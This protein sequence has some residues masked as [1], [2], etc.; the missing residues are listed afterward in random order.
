MSWSKISTKKVQSK[1]EHHNI[2]GGGRICQTALV[3]PLIPLSFCCVAR[4]VPFEVYF[5]LEFY[6]QHRAENPDFKSLFGDEALTLL[7]THPP[8]LRAIW[9]RR[10]TRGRTGPSA[11]SCWSQTPCP[12]TWARTW[13]TRKETSY[14]METAV[15]RQETTVNPFTCLSAPSSLDFT[16]IYLMWNQA[17]LNIKINITCIKYK[18]VSSSWLQKLF[19]GSVESCGH[20]ILM[21]R[22]PSEIMLMSWWVN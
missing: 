16:L 8:S 22:Y 4:N 10:V 19:Q 20:F 11:G 14:W 6:V 12:T 5:L 15:W 7:Y 21:S 2:H 3:C 9:W 17:S 1:T 13:P 18:D